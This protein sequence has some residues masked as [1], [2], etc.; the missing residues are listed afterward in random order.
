MIAA[1]GGRNLAWISRVLEELWGREQKESKL[2]FRDLHS[3]EYYSCKYYLIKG[4]TL[5]K[6]T[7]AAWGRDFWVWIYDPVRK[8]CSNKIT[9][10]KLEQWHKQVQ[11]FDFKNLHLLLGWTSQSPDYVWQCICIPLLPRLGEGRPNSGR[12]ISGTGMQTPAWTN[13]DKKKAVIMKSIHMLGVGKKGY[14]VKPNKRPKLEE[15]ILMKSSSLRL[16]W[17]WQVTTNQ[18]VSYDQLSKKM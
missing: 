11:S 10:R 5:E 14:T 13:E 18:S 7:Q 3:W 15:T 12:L 2:F 1:T 8:S 17:T 9:W 6:M 4:E 16:R